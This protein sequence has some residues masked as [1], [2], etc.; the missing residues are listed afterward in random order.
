T[1]VACLEAIAARR[2]RE[3]FAVLYRRYA[4]RVRAFLLRRRAE[5]SAAT[6][7]MQDVMLTVW[8][9]ADRYDPQ[10]ASVASWVFTIAR[11]RYIDRVRR[12]R[13]PEPEPEEEVAPSDRAPDRRVDAD[14]RHARVRA[15]V[16]SLPEEQRQL[17]A[18]AYLEGRSQTE[19]AAATGLPLGTV[20]S[21]F[22]LA[23]KK[24]RATM[25]SVGE[26]DAAS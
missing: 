22:R 1:D 2:D 25:A 9:K 7:V 11:N 26:E 19:I 5:P 14:R 20:K 16:A 12:E 17:I 23:M 24:L 6:D 15:A 8:H 21:R 18:L 4:P 3:A 13:R 10:R